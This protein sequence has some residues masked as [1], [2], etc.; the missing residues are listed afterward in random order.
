MATYAAK[1]RKTAVDNQSIILNSFG[2]ITAGSSLMPYSGRS[3]Y[4]DKWNGDDG[5]TGLSWEQAFA[6]VQAAITA[7][8]ARIDW[9][10]YPKSIN[11]IYIAPG[12]Y[13]EALTPP[14]DCRMIGLGIPGTD[15]CTEIHPAESAGSAITG[16]ALGLHL[17]NLR[18]ECE[19]V[20]PVLDFGIVGSTIIE[21]CEIMNGSTY[22][23]THGI[24]TETASHMTV[25]GCTFG[26]GSTNLTHGIYCA[27]GANKYFHHCTVENNQFHTGIGIYIASNC[28]GTQSVIRGNVFNVTTLGIDDDSD[29][30]AIID[31]RI[32]SA[33]VL[34]SSYDIN[35][36]KAA[37]NVVTGS[38]NTLDVPIKAV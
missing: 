12:V 32:I 25:K 24:S 30:V 15:Q 35:V 18:F 1:L 36:A 33:A 29:D 22:Q 31:N 16:T 17:Y 20:L 21:D 37:G 27:G 7:S 38:D 9:S 2:E 4:V 3:Y 19:D 10:Y 23:A 5:R 26:S 6:T 8:N 28:T 11:T 13:A 14:Y 34:A